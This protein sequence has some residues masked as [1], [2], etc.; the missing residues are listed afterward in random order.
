MNKVSQHPAVRE[1]YPLLCEAI[2]S[3]ASYQLRNRA[4]VVGNICNAS[5]AGDTIGACLLF[6]GSLSIHGAGGARQESLATF[7][8]G[9]GETTLQSGDIVT[10]LQLPVPA[11]DFVG[12]YKKLN[13]N[14]RGDLAIVGVTACSYPNADIPSGRTVRVALASVAP[15]PLMVPEIEKYF[16]DHD[17]TEECIH[18][19]ANIAREACRPIDDVRG[20]AR[21][22]QMMVRNLTRQALTTLQ[23]YL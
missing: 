5:P 20:S 18:E 4:T 15:T 12:T 21:Y 1:Q 3:V 9:P 6:N 23:A 10:A 19:A 8:K 2:D 13:R 22:R 16:H 17:L 14:Q 7:F 11:A